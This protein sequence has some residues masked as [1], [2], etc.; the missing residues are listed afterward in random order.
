MSSGV[1]GLGALLPRD[2]VEVRTWEWFFIL[3]NHH[4]M[5]L[6]S[7]MLPERLSA[8]GVFRAAVFVPSVVCSLVSP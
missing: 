5:L 6:E 2:W 8:G 7:R 1:E 3:V 4:N